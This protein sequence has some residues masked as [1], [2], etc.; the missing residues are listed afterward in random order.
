MTPWTAGG[1]ELAWSFRPKGLA[2]STNMLASLCLLPFLVA[3]AERRWYLMALFGGT[4][5]LSRT[6]LAG[7]LGL[8]LLWKP[9][10]ILIIALIAAALA[11]IYV[12]VHGGF[13]PGI[14][15]RIAESALRTIADHPLFGVGPSALPA[16]AGW[17]GPQDAALA[18]HAHSTPLDIAA[19]LG[20]PALLAFAV[21]V[22]GGLRRADGLMRI[23]LWATVFDALTVDVE[24]FRHVWLLMGLVTAMQRSSP[25]PPPSGTTAAATC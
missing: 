24:N 17:P 12:D 14:R 4:L 2:R 19:T 22:V 25:L 10:R 7:A 6:A 18:W 16:T 11:S 3:A 5:L 9:R 23:L 13:G 15:W 1:G 21:L 20:L 8:V